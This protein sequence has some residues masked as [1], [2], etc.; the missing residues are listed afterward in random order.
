MG[1]MDLLYQQRAARR[2]PHRGHA[3]ARPESGYIRWHV[4]YYPVWILGFQRGRW[5]RG[6]VAQSEKLRGGRV[7]ASKQ[8]TAS[9]SRPVKARRRA[10]GRPTDAAD[11]V[12]PE[13]LIKAARELLDRLPPA[14]VTRA[15][16]ARHAGVDPSLIRY[17]F[18]DRD[19]LLL[20]VVERI[21]ADGRARYVPSQAAS[22]AERLRDRVRA[23]FQFNA[24]Y[25]FF[26][27]LVTEELAPSASRE[28][29][30]ALQRMAGS[31]IAGYDELLKEG[32][33]DGS[34]R[35]V[36]PMLLHIA[37][38]GMCEFFVS[39]GIVVK[40]ALGKGV[41]QPNA[42]K[43]YADLVASLVVDGLRPR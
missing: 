24:T 42:A 32:L 23:V 5:H 36:D 21:V 41:S 14:K 1:T 8:A 33:R 20:A 2:A 30:E 10:Q 28:A 22:A 7:G 6:R 4:R 18:R 29:R 35:R 40:D 34:L 9:R 43:R 15:A 31:A 3:L 16:V 39:L 26:H 27:R 25:P 13:A 38:T 17:Y 12:G 37:V 19:S 11:T